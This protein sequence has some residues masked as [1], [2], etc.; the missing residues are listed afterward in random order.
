MFGIERT[1][2][3]SGG[4]GGTVTVQ[5]NWI[6]VLTNGEYQ[7]GTDT[8]VTSPKP[9]ERSTYNY[10]GQLLYRFEPDD[11][12]QYDSAFYRDSSLNDVFVRRH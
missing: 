11:G 7:E 12:V 10:R 2:G 5:P 6:D 1:F 3:S 4:G 9:G 8:L